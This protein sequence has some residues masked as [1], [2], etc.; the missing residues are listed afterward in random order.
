MST[1]AARVERSAKR[2]TSRKSNKNKGETSMTALILQ[3]KPFVEMVTPKLQIAYLRCL[4]ALDD[5][6]EARMRNAVPERQLRK[7]DRAIN[8]YRR[9]MHA[10]HK[11][12]AKTKQAER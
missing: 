10:D 9:L 3:A 5:F 2:E 11:S 7:A 6:A 4:R 1:F 8:R 12:P